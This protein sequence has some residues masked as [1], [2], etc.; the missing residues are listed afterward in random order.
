MSIYV[1]NGVG[2]YDA[3]TVLN[4]SAASKVSGANGA[5]GTVGG[6]AKVVDLGAAART[7]GKV[8]IV[9]SENG[10]SAN[11]KQT[12]KLQ[13]SDDNFTADIVDLAIV[14]LGH[15]GQL[16]GDENKGAGKY[17]IPYTNVINGKAYR[18]IRA[19]ANT[20]ATSS[21]GVKYVAYLIP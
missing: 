4:D 7:D 14:E 2:V 1:K 20:S 8:V 9:V 19:F 10:T 21:D 6:Q 5:A 11:M 17:E 3:E 15:A 16:P 12:I 18:Y 13:G